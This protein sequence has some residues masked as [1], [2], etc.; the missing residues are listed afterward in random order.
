M[1]QPLE[2]TGRDSHGTKATPTPPKGKSRPDVARP[3]PDEARAPAVTHPKR[4]GDVVAATAIHIEPDDGL[5]ADA[6]PIMM[7]AY[8]LVLTVAVLTFKGSGEALLAVA[9]CVAFATVF[10]G[11]PLAMMHTR[12]RHDA[13]WQKGAG[14]RPDTVDT[15]TGRVKRAEA[16]VHMAIVPV[17]VSIAFAGF[18][19]IWV[20]SRP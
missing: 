10:F 17:I 3:Q 9:V 11:V 18:A 19:A 14:R 16:V 13:R 7:A 5:L 4:D 1:L 6:G 2:R 12:A 8:G 15:Y 20:L